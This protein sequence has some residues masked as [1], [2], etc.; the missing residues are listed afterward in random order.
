MRRRFVPSPRVLAALA[1]LAGCSTFGP[2]GSGVVFETAAAEYAPG[3]EVS[4]RL[5]NGSDG[6]VGYNL[7]FTNVESKAD[8]WGA[9][10]RP[11]GET[12]FCQA[13]L[14]G[15]EPGGVAEAAVPLPADL[16]AGEYRLVTEVELENDQRVEVTAPF[17][18][19]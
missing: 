5:E 6:D 7:C 9:V 11:D 8:A 18:V 17:E 15:L 19:R 13:I 2:G 4:A 16:P 12:R 1:V 3:S 10:G 14:L